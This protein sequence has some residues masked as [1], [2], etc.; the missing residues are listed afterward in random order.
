M[1]ESFLFHI[2]K[3]F[4]VLWRR[5]NNLGA[6]FIFQFRVGAM[7]F[8]PP[9]R[10]S[11]LIRQ[12][13]T[14]GANSFFVIA[15][16]AVSTGMVIGI[17]FYFAFRQ[18]GAQD[19]MGYTIYAAL[20]RE[21]GPIF[22]ALMIISRAAS[23]MAAELGTM[24]VTE[25]I[26]AID[27]L[28]VDSKAYLIVPR[29]LACLISTPLLIALFDAI[30]NYSAFLLSCYALDV[31]PNAYMN[32]I[33][34]YA[35]FSDFTNGILKGVVFGWMIGAVATYAGYH[36]SGGAK[37]V[38]AATTSAVVIASVSLFLLDYLLS[39]LFLLLD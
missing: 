37:G 11:L 21:L 36:A 24:R 5:V 30:A 12:I 33:L 14:I 28:G 9:F 39:S 27:T 35:F 29:V 16:T 3:P 20:G 19:M 4:F 6:F 1:L 32:T 38:G 25:Q 34:T 2:G 15:L 26:D 18:F 10:L 13:E 17:Q 8:M 31:N 7:M 22:T 23:A